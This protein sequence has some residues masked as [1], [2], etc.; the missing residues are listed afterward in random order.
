MVLKSHCSC[1]VLCELLGL[2]PI[3]K[4]R[5]KERDNLLLSNWKGRGDASCPRPSQL[6]HQATCYK[7]QVGT[8]VHQE[9]ESIRPSSL[10]PSSS[11][12]PSP[13]PLTSPPGFIKTHEQPFIRFSSCMEGTEAEILEQDSIV[14]LVIKIGVTFKHSLERMWRI[15]AFF[16]WKA[17]PR[18]ALSAL[19][20][21]HHLH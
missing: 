14:N 3:H 19:L 1:P 17:V 7:T 4:Y 21:P 12:P 9:Q 15:T 11:S 2:R 6:S 10:Y 20:G 18:P 8:H 5:I 16:V 13:R